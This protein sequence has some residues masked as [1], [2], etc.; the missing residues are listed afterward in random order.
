LIDVE[1]VYQGAVTS[2]LGL[3]KGVLHNITPMEGGRVRLEFSI[4]ARGLI[5]YRSEFLTDTRGT[6]LLNTEF[7]GYAEYK[8]DIASRTTGS[9]I[10]DRAGRATAYSLF[11]LED[12][13]RHFIM[14]GTE[15]YMGMIVGENSK[16]NDLNVNVVREK[17]LTNVRASGKDEALTL[18]P[19][20]PMT[21]E[22]ALEWVGDDELIEITPN[23]IRLRARFLDPNKRPKK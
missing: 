19:V 8:G 2:K 15:V 20:K 21:I 3:R 13:G 18:A 16:S 5:G 17:K 6:G 12:R 9:L 10:S 11:H 4:P 14:P 1:S 23:H 7:A 22:E